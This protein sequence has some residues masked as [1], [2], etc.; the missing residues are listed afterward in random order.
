MNYNFVNLHR[1]A[2][3]SNFDGFGKAKDAAKY[4][5][6]L[7]QTA[8][9]LT[10]HGTI[11]GLIEHYHACKE[12][13]INPILGVEAYFQPKFNPTPDAPRHHLCLYCM[14]IEGYKNLCKMLTEANIN[15]FYR[16]ATITFELLEQYNSGLICSSACIAGVIPQL[17]LADKPQLAEKAALK[18]KSIFG[19]RFYLEI[20]PYN[21]SDVSQKGINE[22]LISLGKKTKIELIVTTDSHYADKNDYDTYQIMHKIAKHENIADYSERY[23][24]SAKE[25]CDRVIKMHGSALLCAVENTQILADRCNVELS[26]EE[27]IPG[28]DWGMPERELLN[29]LVKQGLEKKWKTLEKIN[30]AKP[31]L[32]KKMEYFNRA[33][34]EMQV[35][36]KELKFEGYFLICWDIVKYAK[37][38]NIP[39]GPGRGSVCGS[40]VANL[41]GLTEVDPLILGTD[42]ER[43]LRSDKK[44]LPDIDT[45]VG[46]A[47]RQ[48]VLDYILNKYPGRSAKITAFGYYKK[49]N[50]IND[51]AKI[52][53]MEKSEIIELKQNIEKEVET[54]EVEFDHIIRNNYLNKMNI[55]YKGIIRH[56]CK[57]YG[58]IRYI[59][60]HAAGIAITAGNITDQVALIRKGDQLQ[61]CYDLKALGQINVLK[62][63]I[64]GL[65]TASILHEVEKTA[66]IKID[67]QDINDSEV[68][69]DLRNGK[70]EAVFQ[71]EKATAKNILNRIECTHIQDI[72]ATNAINRPAPLQLGMLEKYVQAKMYYT[73]DKKK[74]WYKYAKETYGTIIYQEQ[75][76]RIGRYMANMSWDDIDCMIKTDKLKDE[77][78]KKQ[79]KYKFV[80]GI[81]NNDKLNISKVLAGKLFDDITLYLFN[82]G[83]AAAYSLIGYKCAELK[84]YYPLEFW[85]ATLKFENDEKKRE[86]YKNHAVK[87]GCVILCPHINGTVNYEIKQIDGGKAIQEGIT[88]I[89]GIGEK[90]ART[91]IENGP[92]IDYPDFEDKMLSLEKTQRR[93]ITKKTIQ[94]LKDNDAMQFNDDLYYYKVKRYNAHLKNKNLKIW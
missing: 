21:L 36:C 85:T 5:K 14:N 84:R 65:A 93:T 18:F 56:F 77:E 33:K 83:H 41:I 24:P 43:F 26:F 30:G 37:E 57:L 92:Y 8:L 69:Q 28:N 58:Q 12:L 70:T 76:M 17:Y 4:A 47:E 35:I 82:K 71:L 40:L 7:G 46:Q 74:A 63:D 87:D 25:V 48:K 23:M 19:D 80:L 88:F 15:N 38:N 29:N 13:D 22:R 79:I 52:Y 62:M 32:D 51:L 81:L 59:G 6:Q 61:T 64:L 2:H 16:T 67:W 89:K 44:A 55:K 1:H 75:V 78:L 50:L 66:D 60:K 94:L 31:D 45:D 91:I 42:F 39:V 10:D 27:K 73:E 54:D 53:E 49:L 3:M 11:S 34:K 20:M 86:V 9:G 68:Y 90:A 72:I